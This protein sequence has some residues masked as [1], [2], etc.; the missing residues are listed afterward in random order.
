MDDHVDDDDNNDVDA[1]YQKIKEILE[2]EHTPSL[3]EIITLL[4][5]ELS[6]VHIYYITRLTKKYK[7]VYNKKSDIE[8]FT[9][10]LTRIYFPKENYCFICSRSLAKKIPVIKNIIDGNFQEQA[11]ELTYCDYDTGMDFS[12]GKLIICKSEIASIL[13]PIYDN[14]GNNLTPKTLLDFIPREY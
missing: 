13:L 1:S 11:L 10:F 6:P 12:G 4:Y 2:D 14:A 7:K 5:K 9:K 8:Y 3:F